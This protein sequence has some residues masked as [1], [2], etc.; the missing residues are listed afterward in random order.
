MNLPRLIQLSK[1][2]QHQVRGISA[3]DVEF[4]RRDSA[5]DIKYEFEKEKTA[6]IN[7]SLPGGERD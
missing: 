3:E 5:A 4:D 6:G 2:I 1:N 7:Y